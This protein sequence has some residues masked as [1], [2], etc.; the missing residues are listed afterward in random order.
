MRKPTI[1]EALRGRLGRNP[2]DAELKADVARIKEE[3]Y[4]MAASAGKLRHQ[5]K[6]SSKGRK[7]D[8]SL[9][10][11]I[12]A[13]AA[14]NAFRP[15]SSPAPERPRMG[16]LKLTRDGLM[17]N[18]FVRATERRGRFTASGKREAGSMTEQLWDNMNFSPEG[19]ATTGPKYA[20]AFF[21][22]ASSIDGWK[23]TYVVWE[24]TGEKRV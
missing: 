18:W 4:V 1:Y 22:W 3:G 23:D 2:T 10:G 12:S 6:P 19:M 20:E 21:K 17:S 5:R 8:S 9:G 13:L 14:K 15:D 24:P 7:K 16:Y 11:M